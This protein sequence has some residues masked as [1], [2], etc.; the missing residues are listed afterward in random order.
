MRASTGRPVKGAAL[1][2]PSWR[3]WC[4]SISSEA[5]LPAWSTSSS[6][7]SFRCFP[8]APSSPASST[9]Q[10]GDHHLCCSPLQVH[11]SSTASSTPGTLLMRGLLPVT[12]SAGPC[13]NQP[14]DCHIICSPRYVPPCSTAGNIAGALRHRGSGY[15]TEPVGVH[16]GHAG[17]LPKQN[18][19]APHR[20]AGTLVTHL[21]HLSRHQ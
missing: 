16:A 19:Q 5:S 20:T 7:D 13:L 14:N 11:P 18:A 2:L 8:A 17:T 6:A 1:P 9:H 3:T 4:S 10:P 15:G 12:Y 21:R